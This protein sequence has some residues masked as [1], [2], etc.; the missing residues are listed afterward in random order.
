MLYNIHTMGFGNLR[1]RIAA[2]Q[3]SSHQPR[4]LTPV[5]LTT[6]TVPE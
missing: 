6:A 5:A 4:S 3:Q 2:Q 1:I